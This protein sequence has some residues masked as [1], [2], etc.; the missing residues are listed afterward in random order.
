MQDDRGA[1][2]VKQIMFKKKWLHKKMVHFTN[3][4]PSP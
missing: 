1:T 3:L 4:P 2:T